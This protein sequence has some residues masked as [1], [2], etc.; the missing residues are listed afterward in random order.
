MEE[1]HLIDAD[2]SEFGHTGIYS[3]VS[4]RLGW[5]DDD[6]VPQDRLQGPAMADSDTYETK[7]RSA[8]LQKQGKLPVSR[9][10]VSVKDSV[11]DVTK[12]LEINSS[13]DYSSVTSVSKSSVSSPRPKAKARFSHS[14]SLSDKTTSSIKKVHHSLS[15]PSKPT[16]SDHSPSVSRSYRRKVVENSQHDLTER[17]VDLKITSSESHQQNSEHGSE[18]ETSDKNNHRDHSDRSDRSKNNRQSYD[19]RSVSDRSGRSTASNRSHGDSSSD[20]KNRSGRNSRY[21]QSDLFNQSN[22]RSSGFKAPDD[23]RDFSDQS[24]SNKPASLKGSDAYSDNFDTESEV[25]SIDHDSPTPRHI[26]LAKAKLGYT[27]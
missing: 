1:L 10:K 13:L 27:L 12:S 2:Q 16:K 6:L 9:T 23:E 14:A 4:P 22:K 7:S 20:H 25:S 21:D 8:R 3:P 5:S 24:N 19:K 17:S 15:E 26:V 11:F 18:A